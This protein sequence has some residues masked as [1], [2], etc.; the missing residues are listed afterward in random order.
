LLS[1]LTRKHVAVGLS[2]DG[3]DELFGGYT[4]YFQARDLW[5]GTGWAPLRIKRLAATALR[6]LTVE[7]WDTAFG[8]PDGWLPASI[9]QRNAGAKLHTLAGILD[10]ASPEAVYLELVSQWSDPTSTAVGAHEPQTIMNNPDRWIASGDFVQR[11]MYADMATYLPDDI[12]VKV[13]RASMSVGL[14]ARVPLLDH[15]LIEF[16]WKIPQSLKIRGG[17]GKW[18][19]RQVLNKYVPK[20]L[21][22]GPKTGFAVPIDRWLRGPLR[23]WAEELL[24]EKRLRSEG[25][26]E[27]LSIRRKWAEHLAGTR[28]GQ[29]ALWSILMFQAWLDEG[30]KYQPAEFVETACVA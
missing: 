29:H 11:M 25:F 2:G 28:N 16:A 19:L 20:R 13:D 5:R 22:A 1:E 27:P 10:A 6:Q 3:G 4:R 24:D 9:Q 26:F 18:L 7:Q 17:Q 15:R 12:L 14:E 30:K 8:Y 23:E 21:I